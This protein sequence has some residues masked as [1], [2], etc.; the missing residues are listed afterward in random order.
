MN[1]KNNL[2]VP[3][4]NKWHNILSANIMLFYVCLNQPIAKADI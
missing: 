3:L 1:Y 2:I 4:N